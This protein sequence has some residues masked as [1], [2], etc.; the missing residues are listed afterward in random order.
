M[1]KMGFSPRKVNIMR[2]I[3]MLSNFSKDANGG[4]VEMAF[5]APLLLLLVIGIYEVS[6]YIAL[7]TKLNESAAS[8][9][10]W[11][12][13]TTTLASIKDDLIG[14]SLLGKDYAF[15]SNG[16]VVVSGIVTINS[17]GN[18]QG[19]QQKNQQGN[20]Q[21]NQQQVVWQVSSSNSLSSIISNNGNIISVPFP[22]ANEPKIIVVEVKYNYAPFF[23]YFASILPTITI[24]KTAQAVPQGQGTFFPLPPS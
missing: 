21:G 9:A 18:Q 13:A 1:V 12:A 17:N 3:R 10:K 19:N 20:Q 22:I 23:S 24:L 4:V 14:V 8:V 11:A 15:S 2:F 6:N 5:A 7:N 16:S